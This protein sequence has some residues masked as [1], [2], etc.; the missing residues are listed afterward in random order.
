MQI[1]LLDMWI[2]PC[3]FPWQ[4]KKLHMSQLG[5]LS[6]GFFFPPCP[7]LE[8]E[9]FASCWLW[10]GRDAYPGPFWPSGSVDDPHWRQ[11]ECAVRFFLYITFNL[12]YISAGVDSFIYAWN[13]ILTQVSCK[14]FMMQQIKESCVSQDWQDW[15]RS[16]L[17][18]S[19]LLTPLCERDFWSE[20]IRCN[21]LH[22]MKHSSLSAQTC[23]NQ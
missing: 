6:W 3:S 10:F 16:D 20:I 17:P 22:A 21:A 19:V 9:L 8:V 4:V 5:S 11:N 14:R 23:E 12:L 13:F 15:S 2:F 1:S 7:T 18:C